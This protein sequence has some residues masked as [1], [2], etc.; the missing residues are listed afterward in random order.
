MDNDCC[1]FDKLIRDFSFCTDELYR[2][3]CAN[4]GCHDHLFRHHRN[5]ANGTEKTRKL[6]CLDHLRSYFYPALFLQRIG[7]NQR[8]VS[9]IHNAGI[10][11]ICG[12]EKVSG[13][14]TSRRC[15][16]CLKLMRIIKPINKLAF[17]MS[18]LM[19]KDKVGKRSVLVA[20]SHH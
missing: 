16:S 10:C 15:I 8:A 13:K 12:L 5:V 2:Q 20:E 9:V 18:Q 3:R 7:V 6:D 17:K 1:T 11:R 14:G 19:R 4:L